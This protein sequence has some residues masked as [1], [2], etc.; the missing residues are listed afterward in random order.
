[1]IYIVPISALVFIFYMM[2]TT[3][4]LISTLSFHPGYIMRGE[5]WRIV[6][7]IF[8]PLNDNL[9][10][11]ALMLFFYYFIGTTLEREW[12]TPKFTVYYIFG[13]L[14]NII[15]GFVLWFVVRYSLG[16]YYTAIDELW[17]LFI[18]LS[19]TYLNLSMFFAFAALFPDHVIR[20]YFIIPIKVKWVALLNAAVFAYSVISNLM[21]GN[22][23]PALL[24]VVSLLNFFL[25]CGYDMMRYLRPAV[26]RPSHQAI[27]FKRAAREARREFDGKH[28]HHKCGVCGKTDT[29]FPDLEFRYCSRC[30]GYQCFCIE[31][32]NS[33]IHFQ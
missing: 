20:I 17:P 23:G 6:T 15:Y 27:D 3:G 16:E 13:V 22:Y 24:P 30:N 28:Y 5:V 33:H 10:F 29:E 19:P 31:H 21:I 25:I 9:I 11:T 12:G 7:W 32:I 8:V 1:M 14:L 2:D 18:R 26:A 4:M